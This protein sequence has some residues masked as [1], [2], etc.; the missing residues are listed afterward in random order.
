MSDLCPICGGSGLRFVQLEKGNRA[1]S[2]CDCKV[3]DRTFRRVSAAKIPARY[4]ELTLDN[5]ITN[6]GGTNECLVEAKWRAEEF[7]K[8]Y[9]WDTYENGL[10]FVGPC[11]VGKTH[12]AVG[13][14]TALIAGRGVSGRFVDCKELLKQVQD[15]YY[16]S[17]L[18][19]ERQ[20][21]RPA[22][23]ADVLVLDELGAARNT[24]WVSDM[25]E[26]I[27][28]MR[29]N[30]KKTTIV[31]T[32]LR[33]APVPAGFKTGD[34][35]LTPTLADRIGERMFS[36]LQEMCVVVNMQDAPDYRA[37]SEGRAS[38]APR[39]MRNRPKTVPE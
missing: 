14:L 27:L 12:L 17:T 38:F 25:V 10:L 16:P 19:T 21:L 32:N 28:N 2:D 22:L 26:H 8:A 18:T 6:R 24:D 33:F 15:S 3:L 5:F 36:R 37:T 4:R 35:N 23:A 31:T 29:Y 30:D 9:P 20:V 13:I 1:V 7:V 39:V 34:A 11:G